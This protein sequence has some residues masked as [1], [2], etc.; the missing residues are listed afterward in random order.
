MTE[1]ETLL[2]ETINR[3]EENNR[4][5]ADVLMESFKGNVSQEGMDKVKIARVNIKEAGHY[6][7]Y[8]RQMDNLQYEAFVLAESVN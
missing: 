5:L 1:R 8:F 6:L 7:N 2:M 4:L 3:L